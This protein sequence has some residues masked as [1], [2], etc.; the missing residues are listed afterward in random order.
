MKCSVFAMLI[1][2]FSAMSQA[3]IL[4]ITQNP[5]VD[6]GLVVYTGNFPTPHQD[7]NIFDAPEPLTV[8]KPGDDVR[9]AVSFNMQEFDPLTDDGL[10]PFNNGL[11]D[12]TFSWWSRGEEQ[13]FNY[14][15]YSWDDVL[16]Q[17]AIGTEMLSIWTDSA[18]KEDQ[19][20]FIGGDWTLFAWAEQQ[21]L[22]AAVFSV[23]EPKTVTLI[24]LL[25][26]LFIALERSN[27]RSNNLSF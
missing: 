12:I 14:I 2:L 8:V 22:G 9:A 21:Y 15:A 24:M 25:I 10:G 16:E 1:M 6:E 26:L 17:Q 27:K 13:Y 11:L 3:S 18:L 5:E 23:D 19:A 7:P 20:L 4:A